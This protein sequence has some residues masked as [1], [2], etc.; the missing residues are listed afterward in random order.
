MILSRNLSKTKILLQAVDATETPVTFYALDIGLSNLRRSLKDVPSTLYKHVQ[1]QGLWGAFSDGLSWLQQPVNASRQKCILSLGATV[2]NF[3]RDEAPTFL[4]QFGT[5]FKPGG[6]DFMLISL[7]ACKDRSRIVTAYNDPEGIN[8]RFNAHGLKH[9]NEILG[10]EVFKD[11]EWTV[12]GE[13]NAELGR[14]EWF[15]SPTKDF[16]YGQYAVYVKE[17]L[18]IIHSYMYDDEERKFL[19]DR[20]GLVESRRLSAKT[21]PYSESDASHLVLC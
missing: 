8:Q 7:D 11:G 15:Y 14:H 18:A 1:C 4:K 20:S 16:R 10:E 3:T 12:N 21:A 6:N 2:G 5:T 13:W 9:A 17:K 19:W